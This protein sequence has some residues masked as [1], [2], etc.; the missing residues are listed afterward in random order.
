MPSKLCENNEEGWPRG[1]LRRIFIA[2]TTRKPPRRRPGLRSMPHRLAWIAGLP[3]L[4]LGAA[5]GSAQSSFSPE[6]TAR[7][8]TVMT[9][10][11][12]DYDPAGIRTG[13]VRLD[14]ALE[15]G[16][17]YDS[18]LVP[19]ISNQRSGAFAEQGLS[20]GAQT[21]WTRHAIGLSASQTTRQYF[22]DSDLNW[23]DWSLGGG[24]RYDIGRASN[25]RLRYDHVRSHIDV[26]NY[27]LQDGNSGRV[28]VP[29]DTD[30]VQLAGT[31]AFNRLELGSSVEY[32]RIRYQDVTV[33]GQRDTVSSNDYDT[34]IGEFTADY[35][36]LPG[37]SVIGLVRLQDIAYE[38][39]GQSG[40]DSFTWEAQGGV[41]YD[42]NGLVRVRLLVG[43]RNRDYD[44]PGRKS[45]SG[46]AFEGEVSWA[47]TQLTTLTFSAQRS[48]E[49]SIRE[50]SVSYT[51]TAARVRVDHEL[52]RNVILSGEVRGE[53][54]KYPQ[55]GGTVSDGI[56]LVEGRYLIN[57]NLALVATYQH[58]E[59]LEAPEGIREYGRDQVLLRLRMAL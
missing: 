33:N 6:A 3:A 18:N 58:T 23:N 27:D 29:V 10:Q 50:S 57:R 56:A 2:M 35:S 19:G 31:A 15:G 14:A 48:I 51:R 25:I 17:G 34:V 30:I 8:V 44:E 37:R 52:L 39:E 24:A 40:R 54:R 7:G 43:Y 26:D 9:R 41:R 53:R 21:D 13:G 20:L 38:R 22:Q 47:A 55:E 49:E 59:R 36:L 11:R 28:P 45:L 46:P 32:R 42:A 1:E 4:L 16:I 5:E 12:P